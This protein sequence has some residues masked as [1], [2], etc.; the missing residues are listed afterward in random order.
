MKVK[1][2]YC[3]GIMMLAIMLLFG[4]SSVAEAVPNVA[5]TGTITIANDATTSEGIGGDIGITGTAMDLS[6][7]STIELTCPSGLKFDTTVSLTVGITGSGSTIE[8]DNLG[9]A[10]TA[11]WNIAGT[12]KT[13][14]IVTVTNVPSGTAS[15][16]LKSVLKVLPTASAATQKLNLTGQKFNLITNGGTQNPYSLDIGAIK[17]LQR[18]VIDSATLVSASAMD[19]HFDVDLNSTITVSTALG[20]AAKADD[21]TGAN[22]VF[23]VADGLGSAPDLDQSG[24]IT[25]DADKKTVHVTGITTTGD[26][27][28]AG[29]TVVFNTII[30]GLILQNA[31]G[32]VNAV[33]SAAGIPLNPSGSVITSVVI[34]TPPKYVGD[35]GDTFYT[36]NTFT[37]TVNA[38][39]GAT[40]KI[41]LVKGTTV[42]TA[43]ITWS[44]ADVT[45]SSGGIG[46]MLM[47]PG[48]STVVTCTLAS[49]NLV[50]TLT[51]NSTCVVQASLDS[52][53]THQDTTSGD[54]IIDRTRPKI[55]S[56]SSP[57]RFTIVGSFDEEVDGT[58][59]V[60]ERLIIGGV[61]A[62]VT[63]T[64]ATLGSD[65]KAFTLTTGLLV[66]STTNTL[67][68][69]TSILDLAGN[70]ADT[71]AKTF[72][73]QGP[74]TDS[75]TITGLS[76]SSAA[77]GAM[78]VSNGDTINV[79]IAGPE[80]ISSVKARVVNAADNSTTGVV[81]VT[82]TF[83]ETAVGVYTGTVVMTS[84]S[85]LVTAVKVQGTMDVFA[86][87]TTSN[88]MLTVDNTAPKVSSATA[89]GNQAALLKFNEI[90]DATNLA[91]KT[92]YLVNSIAPA[93]AELRPTNDQVLLKFA[94]PIIPAGTSVTIQVLTGQKD[95]TFIPLG[96]PNSATY[97]VPA[98]DV[99]APYIVSAVVATNG[100]LV[101]TFTDNSG[102]DA[103]DISTPA[104]T[105]KTRVTLVTK[106]G[107][108]AGGVVTN[109]PLNVKSTF[110]PYTPFTNGTDYLVAADVAD[111]AGNLS[112]D[113][114]TFQVC[115]TPVASA[116][117]DTI[118]PNSTSQVSVTGALG[119]FTAEVTENTTGGGSP[120]GPLSGG[121]PWMVTAGPG[122]N[123]PTEIVVKVT[124]QCSTRTHEV[125]ITVNEVC[126]LTLKPT[127]SAVNGE[128]ISVTASGGTAPYVYELTTVTPTGAAI[129][130]LS[131]DYLAPA[132]AAG[133]SAETETIMAT[134][135]NG[136]SGTTTVKI[137]TDAVAV[138]T[139]GSGTASVTIT[140]PE[141]ATCAIDDGV[142]TVTNCVYTSTED[143]VGVVKVTVG[144]EW[145]KVVIRVEGGLCTVESPVPV[146][147]VNMDGIVD[148]NDF[149]PVLDEILGL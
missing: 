45:S 68:P 14:L 98:A 149:K 33:D 51:K 55:A 79:T 70:W 66:A 71:T 120:I 93:S 115:G 90:M 2:K 15:I 108:P 148:V 134:D 116:N 1:N 10:P 89:V 112:A 144:T 37:A 82:G 27:L 123:E 26:G 119:P 105:S 61:N 107:T 47:P 30:S 132:V 59:V 28:N 58:T 4:L 56:V 137:S 38:T 140:G 67:A 25:L 136:C 94:S 88:E 129:D 57:D 53:S 60:K 106:G 3:V 35:S 19:I 69:T 62:G 49:N 6:A 41:R 135:A 110:R 128:K 72:T 131:G 117:P 13:K 92:K 113:A 104:A 124:D 143:G 77:T 125:T 40:L 31:L 9:A 147:D 133:A 101:V 76:A 100:D 7:A 21:A 20:T 114:K 54:L 65:K 121:G 29:N 5:Y 23:V 145:A 46:T 43:S 16:T 42:G 141:G 83:T 130:P 24:T 99:T 86:Q 118:N 44:G 127:K 34:D 39:T 97:N 126:V 102:S 96:T 48:G 11:A 52:F 84:A 103:V 22:T 122:S 17:I 36:V 142:G 80:G 111:L 12:D 18:P 75:T 139:T 87:V 78:I 63:K 85:S 81:S 32:A 146:Q 138:T 95:L 50:L 8:Y 109:D 74:K 73:T 64:G 91:D